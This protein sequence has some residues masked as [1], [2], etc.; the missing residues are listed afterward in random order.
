MFNLPT[1]NDFKEAVE[2]SAELSYEIELSDT[3]TSIAIN[4]DGNLLLAN[5]SLKQP[6]L[7]LFDLT[8]RGE[9]V[10]RFK[11]GHS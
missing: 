5:V 7:E 6:R 8:K 4:K 2:E 3:V 11:G 9:L 1:S 10:R